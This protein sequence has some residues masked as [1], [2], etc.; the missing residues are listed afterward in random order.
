MRL[1]LS[2][3]TKIVVFTSVMILITTSLIASIVLYSSKTYF[4]QRST[5]NLQQE[6][7]LISQDIHNSFKKLSNDLLILSNIPSVNDIIETSKQHDAL[8]S[9]KRD[10]EKWK[11]R[12]AVI[13]SAIL[14]A[15]PTYTQAR[16]IGRAN[17]GKEILRVNQVNGKIYRT[18]EAELQEKNTEPY[19]NKAINATEGSVIFSAVSYNREHGKIEYPLV[20]TLRIMM[21]VYDKHHHP[22]GFLIFNLDYEKHLKN[23]LLESNSNNKL[24]LFNEFGDYFVYNPKDKT[25]KFTKHDQEIYDLSDSRKK[26]EK[27][28]SLLKRLRK[29][30]DNITISK[31]IYSSSAKKDNVLTLTISVDKNELFKNDNQ[32]IQNILFM[33]SAIAIITILITMVFSKWLMRNLKQMTETISKSSPNDG[34]EQL[35][36][37]LKD[38]VGVLARAFVS[39]TELLRKMALYDSLTGLANRNHFL[40]HLHSA[41]LRA[42]RTKKLLAVCFIDLNRFKYINDHHGHNYGDDLLVSFSKRML[43]IARDTDFIGRL[44]GDEFGIII[45]NLNNF[46]DINA[47]EN[48]L[49]PLLGHMYN[50]KN[51]PIKMTIS[52]GVAIYPLHGQTVDELMKSADI[53]MYEAKK[54]RSGK[55]VIFDKRY[56]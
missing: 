7:N 53:A 49:T 35:P 50:I 2:L 46:E 12:L 44:G 1:H 16:Y 32:I 10:H 25:L 23:I 8:S 34:H 18:S 4:L 37:Q 51:L 40:D 20:P 19:F 36:T 45:E 42:E 22:F 43:S 38:E 15:N 27:L 54:V 17:N 28:N 9:Q 30:P 11:S 31:N 13:F 39:K 29:K 48:R 52:V 14:K 33:L 6:A 47:I 56:Q 5:E 24:I 21:P 55:W 3:S 26:S 41:I